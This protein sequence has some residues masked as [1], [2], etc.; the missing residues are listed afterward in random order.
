LR[1]SQGD[2]LYVGSSGTATFASTHPANSFSGNT[3][4]TNNYGNCHKYGGGT[5]TGSCG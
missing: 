3:G 4:G 5:I 1:A 2:V